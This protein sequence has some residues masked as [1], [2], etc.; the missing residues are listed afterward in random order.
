LVK[1]GGE[2]EVKNPDDW[3][4]WEWFDIDE[5]PKTLCTPAE[6]T[7]RSFLQGKVSVSEW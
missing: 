7:L 6:L 1:A 3:E 4:K 5:L 2:P